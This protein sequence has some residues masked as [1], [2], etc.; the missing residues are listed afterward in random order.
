MRTVA[1]G[2][3]VALAAATTGC[4][5]VQDP[6]DVKAEVTDDEQ[7]S[8]LRSLLPTEEVLL[9]SEAVR[10]GA[11]YDSM[12]QPSMAFCDGD[13]PSQGRRIEQRAVSVGPDYEQLSREEINA[14]GLG[15]H[16]FASATRFEP[17]QAKVA[18]DELRM[19]VARC[20]PETWLQDEELVNRRNEVHSTSVVVD[21]LPEDHVVTAYTELIDHGP[22]TEEF[23]K[24]LVSF[25]RGDVVVT[26][27][28]APVRAE[29][30]AEQA[31][32]RLAELP[33]DEVGE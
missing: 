17:G 19:A 21:G 12:Q 10:G 24:L 16:V 32:S 1:V 15:D 7:P 2:A 11:F 20:D 8:P 25:R 33:A 3:L 6:R 27:D 5:V 23:E 30:F 18:L 22:V 9:A 29:V 14:T 28:G 31:A 4:G 26:I 13:L